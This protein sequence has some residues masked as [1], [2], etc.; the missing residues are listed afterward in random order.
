MRLPTGINWDFSA[1][2]A[3]IFHVTKKIIIKS[4]WG[5]D[6]KSGA[7]GAG[8]SGRPA[9]SFSISCL[10]LP[11]L[12]IFQF[13]FP[14]LIGSGACV[15]NYANDIYYVAERTRGAAA[16]ISISC[17]FSPNAI[18]S[19]RQIGLQQVFSSHAVKFDFDTVQITAAALLKNLALSLRHP[20][21]PNLR[22]Q[23]T[24][25]SSELA[26]LQAEFIINPSQPLK[27]KSWRGKIHFEPD[28]NLQY[29]NQ[30]NS[31]YVSTTCTK[32]NNEL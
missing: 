25:Q 16:Q 32:N 31:F 8:A 26:W 29:S 3:A 5:L 21:Q 12:F 7:T 27:F 28:M 1:S 30:F 6:W 2:T 15:K 22:L 24:L 17:A 20:H 14:L 11:A 4:V 18:C 13:P 10:A 9:A 23:I 19:S